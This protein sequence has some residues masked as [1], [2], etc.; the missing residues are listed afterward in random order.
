MTTQLTHEEEV[1]AQGLAMGFT[2]HSASVNAGFDITP[3]EAAMMSQRE[4][5]KDRVTNIVRFDQF[6][7]SIEQLRIA[8]QLE[9][10][11]DF[12][13][14]VGNPA[15]AINATV[16]RAKLLGLMV[17]RV[18]SNNNVAVRSGNDL[19]PEEWSAK[20]VPKEQQSE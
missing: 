12:A 4:E 20:F 7:S 10:D 5:I 8:R 19:S 16:Q 11:R 2:P 9:V 17:E 13:Y 14:A 18:E 3:V 6:D 15:A 1:F